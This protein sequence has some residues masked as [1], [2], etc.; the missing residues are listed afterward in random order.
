LTYKELT[1]EEALKLSD[2]RR[3]SLIKES[4][5][6]IKKLDDKVKAFISFHQPCRK[7]QLGDRK[8]LGYS[9]CDKG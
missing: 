2:E 8:V 1:I 9:H 7:S 5:D 4:L 6:T 3:K